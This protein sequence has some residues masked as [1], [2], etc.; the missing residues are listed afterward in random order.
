[1]LVHFNFKYLK[2]HFRKYVKIAE[3]TIKKGGFVRYYSLCA[4]HIFVPTI[5]GSFLQSRNFA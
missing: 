5:L 3:N 2:M 1:M 4:T